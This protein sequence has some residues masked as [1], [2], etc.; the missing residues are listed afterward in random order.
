MKISIWILT[1]SAVLCAQFT[2]GTDYSSAAK[3]EPENSIEAK[4]LLQTGETEWETTYGDQIIYNARSERNSFGFFINGSNSAGDMLLTYG[5]NQEISSLRMSATDSAGTGSVIK[6]DPDDTDFDRTGITAGIVYKKTFGLTAG[7]DFYKASEKKASR[8]SA[9]LSYNLK[10][11]EA[12][13]MKIFYEAGFGE[14]SG[15]LNGLVKISKI[16]PE[17]FFGADYYSKGENSRLGIDLTYSDYGS[18]TE[19]DTESAYFGA[20]ISYGY[21]FKQAGSSVYAS[22]GTNLASDFTIP[23]IFLPYYHHSIEY[24]NKMFDGKADLSV[25]WNYELFESFLTN[26]PGSENYIPAGLSLADELSEGAGIST[27]Y[28]KISYRY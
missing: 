1:L 28:L 21:D 11:S 27:I 23:K 10:L 19:K 15:L 6:F 3:T 17:S 9:G 22:M 13:G 5:L 26:M 16:K 24:S 14:K 2:S 20:G 18:L 4:L 7:A 8:Y 25:G 12:R